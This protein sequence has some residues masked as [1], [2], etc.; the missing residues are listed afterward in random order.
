MITNKEILNNILLKI[1]IFTYGV[2]IIVIGEILLD[3]SS[4]KIYAS[5]VLYFTPFLFLAINWFLLNY[6]L[7]KEYTKS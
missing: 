4:K 7:K 6:F 2:A 5:L 1:I 3:L